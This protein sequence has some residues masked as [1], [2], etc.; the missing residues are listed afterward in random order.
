MSVKS[1]LERAHLLIMQAGEGPG[2]ALIKNK[3]NRAMLLESVRKLKLAIDII[4]RVL[5][6]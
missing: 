1:D 6:C 4:E 5:G 3:A 2:L